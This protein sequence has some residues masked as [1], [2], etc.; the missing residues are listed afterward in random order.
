VVDVNKPHLANIGR[1]I[2][3]MEFDM[4]SNLNELYV[5]KTR[6][7]IHSLHRVSDTGPVQQ[8]AF[9]ASL[10]AA[11]ISKGAKNISIASSES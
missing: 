6:E 7:I 1:M 3:D 8:S 4:R 9:I 11:V 10:N 5:M 2:E